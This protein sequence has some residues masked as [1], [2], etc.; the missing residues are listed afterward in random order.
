MTNL[1]LTKSELFEAVLSLKPRVAAF[2]CDGTL[3]S[4]DAGEGFYSW[5]MKKQMVSQELEGWARAPYADY[6]ARNV[7]ESVLC[8]QMVPL[9]RG[10]R[11]DDMQRAS[12]EYFALGIPPGIF[13]ETGELV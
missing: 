1:T 6:K 5:S 3:W 2:D 7:P 13:E 10:L 9:Y 4:G 12:D 11:E 8:G